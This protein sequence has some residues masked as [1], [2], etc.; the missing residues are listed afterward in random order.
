MQRPFSLVLDDLGHRAKQIFF[1]YEENGQSIQQNEQRSPGVDT[2]KGL[3]LAYPFHSCL[4]L[5][6]NYSRNMIS[7]AMIRE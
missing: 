4:L 5:S 3:K 2:H 6:E 7:S 1:A